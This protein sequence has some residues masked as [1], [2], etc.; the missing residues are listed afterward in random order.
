MLVRAT[1]LQL[2]APKLNPAVTTGTP[3]GMSESE[4]QMHRFLIEHTNT[5]RS[6]ISSS[7]CF[8]PVD[9]LLNLVEHTVTARRAL[10][11]HIC[12]NT[13]THT[14]TATRC[15]KYSVKHLFQVMFASRRNL[16]EHWPKCHGRWT[17]LE[18]D[19]G[20]VCLRLLCAPTA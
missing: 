11:L 16:T 10:L 12:T 9:S 8:I 5:D 3:T 4:C 6:L 13:H 1:G 18:T 20:S 2:W 19:S 17:E 14:C 7:G 15:Y